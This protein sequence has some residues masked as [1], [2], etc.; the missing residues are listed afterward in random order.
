MGQHHQLLRFGANGLFTSWEQRV[1]R[2][3]PATSA[4]LYGPSGLAVDTAGNI[5]IAD[6]N[7]NRIRKVTASTGDISTAAGDGTYG[8]NGDDIAATSAEL[9][10]PEGVTVE[11]IP[12]G[13]IYIADND[14]NR[15]RA[16]GQ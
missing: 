15:I 12:L 11:R 16:V 10:Y 13:D 4:E 14:N 8:Y 5:Y 6:T 7:N 3:Q 9:Y 1:E 2:S